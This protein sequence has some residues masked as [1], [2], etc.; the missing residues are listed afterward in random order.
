MLKLAKRLLATVGALMFCVTLPAYAQNSDAN[1]EISFEVF[2]STLKAEYAKYN[3][4]FEI[5]EAD[6]DF[7]YTTGFLN[8]Q[9]AIANDFCKGLTIEAIDHPIAQDQSNSPYQP[10]SMP[11]EFY[12]QRSFVIKSNAFIVPALLNVEAIC[13]GDVD[14]QNGV[15]INYRGIVREQTAVNFESA[16]LSLEL[17]KS[18]DETTIMGMLVGDVKFAW[19]DP[20]TNSKFSTVVYGPFGAFTIRADE[21]LI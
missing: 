7:V 3:V 12:Y 10:S 8:E 19:T 9:L 13:Y 14:L 21:Y 4:G 1:Q 16:D 18:K 5:E 6:I 2:Y 15:I 20:T 11:A 17:A